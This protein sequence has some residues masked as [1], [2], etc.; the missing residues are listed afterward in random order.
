M[1]CPSGHSR[2][3]VHGGWAAP[4]QYGGMLQGCTHTTWGN[5]HGKGCCLVDNIL[6]KGAHLSDSD[7]KQDQTNHD[8]CLSRAYIVGDPLCHQPIGGGHMTTLLWLGLMGVPHLLMVSPNHGAGNEVKLLGPE[9]P[10][11]LGMTKVDS[12]L[13]ISLPFL[14]DFPL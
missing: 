1:A 3:P 5:S 7:S 11:Y 9:V 6:H 12:G 14:V 2:P 13:C 10:T 4:R 8:S